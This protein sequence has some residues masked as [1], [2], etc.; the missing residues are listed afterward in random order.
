MS[1]L[2]PVLLIVAV[3]SGCTHVALERNTLK[4]N[5][6]WTDLQYQQVLN[7]LAMFCKNPSALPYFGVAGTGVTQ[8]AD[9]GSA[10]GGFLF[11][12]F[13]GGDLQGN[14]GGT[15]GRQISEQWS[16][17]TT[18][19][20]DRLKA[21][22]CLFQYTIGHPT[23]RDGKDCIDDI[24]EFFG[25]EL[26]NPPPPPGWFHVGCKKDVPKNTC[27]VGCCCDCYV[28]VTPEG[29]DSLTKLT[30]AILDIVTA[31]PAPKTVDHYDVRDGNQK[32]IYSVAKC[33]TR[34]KCNLGMMFDLLKSILLEQLPAAIK[35][36]PNAIKE[37]ADQATHLL[38]E[39]RPSIH[40]AVAMQ[41]LES[42]IEELKDAR[43]LGADAN[44]EKLKAINEANSPLAAN[45]ATLQTF[46]VIG[47]PSPVGRVNFY[48]PLQGLQFV[49]SRR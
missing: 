25:G 5:A 1:R 16:V 27:Y 33:T 30:L 32:Q 2:C 18:T 36:N 4:Q 13:M 37:K 29:Y 43:V 38:E 10:T 22:Q 9:N 26:E 6:T 24:K 7:N 34:G 44:L 42:L 14:L 28:W 19:D 3:G 48:S 46:A 47:E 41:S 21:I 12:P 45:L 35:A 40:N 17:A 31:D 39:I 11:H 8:V 20:P 15:V 23:C 49:P